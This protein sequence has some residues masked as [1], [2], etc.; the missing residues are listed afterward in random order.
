MRRLAW[1]AVVIT[2]LLGPG[3]GVP[4]AGSAAPP[5]G[6]T[7]GSNFMVAGGGSAGMIHGRIIDRT[8]PP[9]PVARQPV[10]LQI[11]ERGTTSERQ[12]RTDA[13]GAFVFS[14]LPLGGLRIFLV[15]TQYQGASYGTG[16]ILL[17]A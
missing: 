7:A 3:A 8:A 4:A 13:A 12:T 15:S 6:D 1:L 16:R 14:G 17:T 5:G 9:H 10:R 11:V 2:A